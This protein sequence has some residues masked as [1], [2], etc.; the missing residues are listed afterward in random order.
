M[1]LQI[2]FT[3]RKGIFDSLTTKSVNL[4]ISNVTIT[5]T[6]HPW[7]SNN[8]SIVRT[9]FF[10]SKLVALM[11]LSA[12]DTGYTEGAWPKRKFC[13]SW[14]L[15]HLACCLRVSPAHGNLQLHSQMF[16]KA[17]KSHVRCTGLHCTEARMLLF[18]SCTLTHIGV[19]AQAWTIFLD[20]SIRGTCEYSRCRTGS[21]WLRM[22]DE[23]LFYSF[24][25][26]A[27]WRPVVQPAAAPCTTAAAA[28]R[29]GSTTTALGYSYSYSY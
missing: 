15:L 28:G 18:K 27:R 4:T 11:P 8:P 25:A 24:E 17:G 26:I 2:L 3:K 16:L 7:W 13:G 6:P 20:Q 21:H 10:A 14:R 22:R 9:H 19:S 5:L 23:F 29:H 12:A 1:N